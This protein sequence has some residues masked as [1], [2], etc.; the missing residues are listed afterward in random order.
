MTLVDVAV[1]LLILA[2]LAGAILPLLPGAPLIFAGALL[3]AIAT[4]FTPVGP[5]RLAILAALGIL[6]WVLEHLAS[7][8]GVR[9][10]GG[11]RAAVVGALGGMIVG[12]MVAPIG[13]LVGP[14]VG[15]IGGELLAGR[16][17]GASV[18]S[19]IGAALGVLTGVVAHFALALVMVGLF[20]WW[21]WR[22]VG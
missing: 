14:I 16:A 6:A 19:G 4:D 15:A 12:V 21:V 9:R 8:V 22:G 20:V 17:P 13:L 2:G 3:H 18:K 1:A 7:V 10:A 5:G 11:G